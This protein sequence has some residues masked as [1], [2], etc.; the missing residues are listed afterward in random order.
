M[1]SVYAQQRVDLKGGVENNY[2][3]VF[4]NKT[5]ATRPK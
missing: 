2:I 5:I 3:L 4:R 1:Q